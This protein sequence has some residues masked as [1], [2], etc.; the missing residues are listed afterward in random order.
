[1]VD[2]IN[3]VAAELEMPQL[4]AEEEGQISGAKPA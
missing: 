4:G 2:V 1:V 3:Q